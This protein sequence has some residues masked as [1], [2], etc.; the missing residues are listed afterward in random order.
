MSKGIRGPR[1]SMLTGITERQRDYW[2]RIG[3][4][5][6]SVAPGIGSGYQRLYSDHDVLMALAIRELEGAGLSL[7]FIRAVLSTGLRLAIRDS[8]AEYRWQTGAVG[9]TLDL[10]S[11]RERLHHLVAA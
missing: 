6:P 11:L 2:A 1:L 7:P 5:V 9:H 3:L 10:A 8:R 4:L